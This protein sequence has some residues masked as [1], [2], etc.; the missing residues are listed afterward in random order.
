[1]STGN[2]VA[3]NE[4]PAYSPPANGAP[5]PAP[6]TAPLARPRVVEQSARSKS[7]EH[8]VQRLILDLAALAASH[9]AQVA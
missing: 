1:M 5:V 7:R 6:P 2:L 3:S 8:E 4:A 9:R